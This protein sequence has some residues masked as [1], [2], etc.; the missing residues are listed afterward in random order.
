MK[1][2]KYVLIFVGFGVVGTFMATFFA[3]DSHVAETTIVVNKPIDL[4]FDVVHEPDYIRKWIDDVDSITCAV[5]GCEIKEGY[6]AQ[7]H[8]TGGSTAMYEITE[9]EQDASVLTQITIDDRAKLTAG[10]SL[11]AIDSSTTEIYVKSSLEPQGWLYK[12]ML[13]GAEEGFKTKRAGEVAKL[14][15]LLENLSI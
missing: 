5:D 8:F 14:K 15:Q 12:V 6:K 7:L 11:K 10:Y 1:I 9:M 3:P 2:V 13:S 4:C